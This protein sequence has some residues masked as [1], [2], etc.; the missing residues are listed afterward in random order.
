MKP[1]KK[2]IGVFVCHCGINIAATVDVERLTEEMGGDP[3]VS[4][5]Q[6]YKYMCSEPG[7]ALIREAI[8]DQGLEGV[9]VACC[10]PSLHEATFRRAVHSA[11]MNPYLCE[12]ANIREQ[13]AWV[14]SD[15]EEATVKAR[16]IVGSIVEKVRLND[17]LE[18]IQVP[19]TKKA[20]VVGG[21][22]T[23]I[24]AAL[25]IADSG[26]PVI[27]VEREARLGGRVAELS[28]TFLTMEKA[29]D[30]L[31]AKQEE[32]KR[33]RNVTIHTC[34]RVEDLEG[35]VGN[36]KAAIRKSASSGEGCDTGMGE[37]IIEEEV[38]AVV[39]ATGYDLYPKEEI[40]GYGAGESPD[41]VDGLEFERMLAAWERGEGP[42]ARPSDGKVPKEVVFVQC[43]GSRDREHG[44]PYCSRICC[45]Y[46]AKQAMLYKKAVPDGQAYVFY[47]D[48]RTGGKGFEEFT[49]EGIADDRLVYIRGKVSKIFSEG[50]KVMVWGADTLM[51]KQVEI[52]A[53]LVVLATAM[54]PA[55]GAS[56]LAKTLK[57]QADEHGFFSEV[58]PKLRPLESP[59]A[60]IFLAGSA[61]A[62][63]DIPSSLMHASGA[64]SKVLSLFSRGE[65]SHE[66]IVAWVDEDLCTGCGVC[67]EV[68]PYGA[69]E[70]SDRK[71]VTRVIEV[72]CQ[73]CGACVAACPNN[74]CQQRNMEARQCLQMIDSVL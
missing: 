47:I 4:L 70:R 46:T 38:G 52:A 37:E 17:S 7:Q 6:D 19:V 64:A 21:G 15:K 34:A 16:E 71:R 20:L 51:G 58:H 49:Q 43:A 28:D 18:P 48:I 9:V 3:A 10:S 8:R 54:T 29:P 62:P 50:E 35:Y 39:A 41:I 66:P 13:C 61:R 56:D 42:P 69:R 22:I 30:I 57:I 74:A 23:G 72:L 2:G 33:H 67:V 32:L 27:L 63:M 59:T 11:G 24:Q 12:I 1:A 5:A 60:G 45:M 26:Y 65:I 40:G 44:V 68:C 55:E 31:E 25:D 14:H 36:F 73:A 53:D